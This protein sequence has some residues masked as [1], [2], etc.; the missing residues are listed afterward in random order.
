[1][2]PLRFLGLKGDNTTSTCSI[3]LRKIVILLYTNIFHSCGN[4]QA[5]KALKSSFVTNCD[6]SAVTSLCVLNIAEAIK[7]SCRGSES[8]LWTIPSYSIFGN[9]TILVADL[10]NDM[11]QSHADDL[12]KESYSVLSDIFVF[13]LSFHCSTPHFL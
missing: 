5:H 9:Y 3:T 11:G 13:L 2:H 6:Q 10:F 7:K 12:C 4:S 8:S 1:M